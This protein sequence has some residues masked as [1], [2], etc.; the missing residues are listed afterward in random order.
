MNKAYILIIFFSILILNHTSLALSSSSYL[1]ANSA[2][3][4]YD[5]NKAKLHY[6]IKNLKHFSKIDLNKKLLAFINSNDIYSAYKVADRI[7][8]IDKL[9]QEAWLAYLVYAKKT[10]DFKAFEKYEKLKTENSLDIIDFIFYRDSVLKTNNKEISESIFEIVSNSNSEEIMSILNY[11]YFLYYLSLSLMLNEYYDEAYFYSANIYQRLKKYKLAEQ[12]YNQ[13]NDEH[14]LFLEAK[15]NIALI[16]EIQKKIPE[17][18][19]ELLTLVEK[20]SQN[21]NLLIS[22]AD[23]YRKSKQYKKA[24][25]NY[26]NILN[27]LSIEEDLRWRILYLRGI[28][29][30]RNNNW[31]S[32]ENDFLE[33]LKINKRSPQVLNYLA[34]GWIERNKFLKKSLQMLKDAHN[35]EP[36]SFYILDSLAWAYFKMKN[37][38]LALELMEEVLIMAPSEAI[39]LDHLGDI[40]FEVGRTREA[41]FMWKQA[42]DL[43]DPED[44]IIDNIISKIN[45]Y[46]AS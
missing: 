45:K 5:Y 22:L 33:S 35:L 23:L 20:Y 11:D 24:I 38:E 8:E 17:A 37:Y 30:E 31:T 34:Y 40:Y 46:N 42:K 18:E 21:E 41:L 6:D 44:D 13:I 39:S 2:I 36:D 28:C 12:Y 32:A 7:I 29:Y 15:K 9:N 14:F 43:A 26:S 27:N 1:I 4:L 19:N 16:K 25:Y 10:N 3:M